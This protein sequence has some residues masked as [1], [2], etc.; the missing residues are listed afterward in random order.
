M[1]SKERVCGHSLDETVG[2]NTARG[3]DVSLVS[4]VCC[5]VEV[6]AMH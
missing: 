3:M 2:S 4:A 5:R 6:S 1:Q